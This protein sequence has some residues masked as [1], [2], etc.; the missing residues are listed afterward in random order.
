[1]LGELSISKFMLS[2]R[3]TNDVRP[4]ADILSRSLSKSLINSFKASVLE[5]L[6]GGGGW[7]IC[8][9]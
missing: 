2:S 5:K 3:V 6:G 9:R 1:M 7:V 4:V 8:I